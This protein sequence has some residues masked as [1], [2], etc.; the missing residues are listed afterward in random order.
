[1]EL[2]FKCENCG[3]SQKVVVD[4]ESLSIHKPAYEEAEMPEYL[5]KEEERKNDSGDNSI[6]IV[7]ECYS[8]KKK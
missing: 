7:V 3:K 8:C 6:L 1:M 5:K 4:Q 2:P